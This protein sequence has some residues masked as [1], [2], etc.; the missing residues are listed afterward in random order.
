MTDF[1][2][3]LLVQWFALRHQ[4]TNAQACLFSD[5]ENYVDKGNRPIE[6]PGTEEMYEEQDNEMTVKITLMES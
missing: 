4:W 2:F 1:P 3:S 6:N 5:L